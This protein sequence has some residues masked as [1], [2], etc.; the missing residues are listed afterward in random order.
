MIAIIKVITAYFLYEKGVLLGCK[1]EPAVCRFPEHECLQKGGCPF[2]T[3]RSGNT[4]V[5][6]QTRIALYTVYIHTVKSM[7]KKRTCT[8]WLRFPVV[9]KQCQQHMSPVARAREVSL[10]APMLSKYVL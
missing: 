10:D 7:Q 5:R 1:N 9:M 2:V 6:C 8:I 4:T 3:G